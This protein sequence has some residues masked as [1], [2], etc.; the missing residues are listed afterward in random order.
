MS[1]VTV[2]YFV[3]DVDTTIGFYTQHLGF[4]LTMRPATSP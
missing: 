2:R 3:D 4:T 1:T